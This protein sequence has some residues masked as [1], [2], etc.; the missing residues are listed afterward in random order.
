[1]SNHFREI[2]RSQSITLPGNLE[3]WLEG[4]DLAHFIVD[5]VEMLDTREIEAAYR[6]GGSAPYP[7]KMLLALLFYCYTKGI[8]TSRK[9]ERAT[10]ELI[11]V[12]YLT[13]GTHPD[14]DSINTFRQRFLPH[15]ERLFVQILLIAHALGVVKLGEVSLDGTKIEA[16]ASKHHALSWAYAERLEQQLKAEVQTLLARAAVVESPGAVDIDLPA[17]LKRREDRLTKIAEVKIEI[18]RRAQERYRRER[19]EYEAKQAA[20]RPRH[21]PGAGN[22][23]ASRPG[24]RSRSPVRRSGQFHRWR[25]PDHAGVRWGLRTG[26]QCPSDRDDGEPADRRR[27]R[28][29]TRQ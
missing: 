16:N 26:L 18:E 15:F 2:D 24:N 4:H 7:P 19:A 5:V 22:W 27:P 14:H 6:G 17:E 28:D 20:R 3:G 25:F 11:P 12:L 1:M 13:G 8:F 21:K 9:I 23:A 10:Y 29:P